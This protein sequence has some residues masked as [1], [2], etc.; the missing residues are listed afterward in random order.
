[1]NPAGVDK[2]KAQRQLE[3]ISTSGIFITNQ[4]TDHQIAK[5]NSDTFSRASDSGPQEQLMEHLETLNRM[6]DHLNQSESEQTIS[7]SQQL[8]QNFPPAESKKTNEPEED[9]EKSKSE[10]IKKLQIVHKIK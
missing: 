5:D 7:K 6:I 2:L 8:V 3:S 4:A 1:M 10:T 9:N